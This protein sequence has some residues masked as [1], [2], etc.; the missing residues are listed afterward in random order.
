MPWE[1][2][3]VTIDKKSGEMTIEGDGFVGNG[4]SVLEEV[5]AQLGVIQYT[6]DKPERHQYVQPDYVPNALGN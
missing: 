2:V 3:N 6:E 4:C 5:E 1:K